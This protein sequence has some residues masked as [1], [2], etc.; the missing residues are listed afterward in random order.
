V[1]RRGNRRCDDSCIG[2]WPRPGSAPERKAVP[3]DAR[4][5]EPNLQGLGIAAPKQRIERSRNGFGEDPAAAAGC[6]M[7]AIA[8]SREHRTGEGSA[9]TADPYLVGHQV[10]RLSPFHHLPM[11]QDTH[12]ELA[13]DMVTP[14]TDVL[15]N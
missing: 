3:C 12:P 7:R 1:D 4:P 13:V 5:S 11:T 10:N 14:A 8:Q 15:K 9:T 6:A 2:G